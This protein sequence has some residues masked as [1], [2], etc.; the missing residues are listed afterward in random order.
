MAET[1]ADTN[2]KPV[3]IER[4]QSEPVI[5]DRSPHSANLIGSSRPLI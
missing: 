5:I 1:I 3:R 4:I 2:V